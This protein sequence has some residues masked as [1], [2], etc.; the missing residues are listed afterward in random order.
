MGFF[1]GIKNVFNGVKNAVSNGVKAIFGGGD[2]GS[3][4][5]PHVQTSFSNEQESVMNLLKQTITSIENNIESTTTASN[6]VGKV[7][8]VAT[9]GSKIKIDLEQT[10]NAQASQIYMSLIEML[11]KSNANT[12]VKLDA[13]GAVCQAVQNDGNVLSSPE[14]A[15]ANIKLKNRNENNI[16]NIQ[17]LN[18]NLKLAVSTC[19]VN[20]FEGGNFLADE[21]SEIIFKL[22]QKA[23]AYSDNLMKMVTDEK[24]T[25][26]AKEK[27]AMKSQIEADNSAE[28]RGI[29]AGAAQELGGTV[30]NISDNVSDSV[31]KISGDVA[32]TAQ[33]IS[34]DV[35]DTFKMSTGMIIAAIAVPII[36][37]ILII[38]FIIIYSFVKKGNESGRKRRYD[39]YDDDDWWN[40]ELKWGIEMWIKK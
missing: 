19:A 5:D 15:A 14:T 30:R 34:G 6:N 16:T 39:D 7:N 26:D 27:Q 38:A 1:D 18:Q 8:M 33:K 11:M 2:S 28:G 36:I 35:S 10:A 24:S 17:K 31:Q 21:D 20:N 25:L 4:E 13:L 22:N 9:K 29:I 40:E 23:D 3:S 37:I 12:D 32:Q